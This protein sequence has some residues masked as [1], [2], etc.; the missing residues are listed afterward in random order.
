MDKTKQ[1]FYQYKEGAIKDIRKALS[2]VRDYTAFKQFIRENFLGFDTE[3]E[4]NSLLISYGGPTFYILQKEEGF[5][6]VFSWEYTIEKK[7]RRSKLEDQLYDFF[8]YLLISYK[9]IF[10]YDE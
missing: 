2:L 3:G 7:I 4:G 1:M 9:S 10:D 8:N 5:Y 6:W